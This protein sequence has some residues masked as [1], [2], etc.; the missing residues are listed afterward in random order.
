[1]RKTIPSTVFF[2]LAATT[3]RLVAAEPFDPAACAAVIAPFVDEQ[4]IVVARV[5]LTRI[6]IG[7]AVKQTLAWFPELGKEARMAGMG[8]SAML[9]ALTATGAREV[10]TVVSLADLN[11][12]DTDPPFLIFPLSEGNEGAALAALLSQAPFE[13]VQRIG[14]VMF[15]GGRRALERIKK[16]PPDARPELIAAFKAAGDTTAQ[17]LLLP[18]QHTARVIEEMMPRLPEELGGGASTAV[19]HG[20]RWAAVGLEGPPN[21]SLRLVVQSDDEASARGFARLL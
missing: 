15:A 1:M 12:A 2:L 5:D 18:P 10:Y 14:P 6:Q 11:F 19:T 3:G 4:A 17:V 13:V 21:L 16:G 7:A 8:A 20:M 9:A